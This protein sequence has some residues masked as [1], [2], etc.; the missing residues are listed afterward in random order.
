MRVDVDI[1]GTGS[2]GIGGS[3]VGWAPPGSVPFVPPFANLTVTN[4]K[5]TETKTVALFGHTHS[6]N[7]LTELGAIA[8]HLVPVHDVESELP[9]WNLGSS[10]GFWHWL[11]VSA[12]KFRSVST[13]QAGSDLE[14]LSGKLHTDKDFYSDGC[15]SAGGIGT[16]PS[17]SGTSV[18]WETVV[19]GSYGTLT[20]D[21]SADT[22]VNLSIYGHNHDDLY[23]RTENT[24]NKQQVLDLI[25][26]ITGFEYVIVQTLPEP[27]G[28][29]T[30]YKI[31]LVPATNPATGNVYNEF[32]TIRTGESPYTY[33]WE[34]IGSTA[35]DLNGFVTIATA[36]TITGQKTFSSDILP[37]SISQNLGDTTHGWGGVYLK[38][39]G[40]IN[41]GTTEVA[42]FQT[43]LIQARSLLPYTAGGYYLG[44][45]DKPW[46]SLSLYRYIY[47]VRNNNGT[48]ESATLIGQ[49]GSQVYIG[50]YDLTTWGLPT[51]IYSGGDINIYAKASGASSPT[52]IM[53][54]AADK[55]TSR[56]NFVPS[57]RDNYDLGE[58]SSCW[59]NLFASRWYLAGSSGPYIDYQTYNGG[60]YIVNH[61][62]F[63]STGAVT[64]GA[65][66]ADSS[67][68][69]V[70]NNIIPTSS[71]LAI[72]SENGNKFQ[73]IYATNIG[74]STAKVANVHAVSANITSA[75]IITLTVAGTAS[76]KDSLRIDSLYQYL[77]YSSQEITDS[78]VTDILDDS[79][80]IDNLLSGVYK[81]INCVNGTVEMKMSVAE[82]SVSSS[83]TVI[84]FGRHRRLRKY[85]GTWT[86]YNYWD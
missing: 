15:I 57:Y 62:N 64:A 73:Y 36:Q 71:T 37:S 49:N 20:V 48:Y 3:R 35:I 43:S 23:Y 8:N 39:N 60:N 18:E 38:S 50:S 77:N 51:G 53:Q 30:M 56:V 28:E 66:G 1:K 74:S 42:K 55:I 31:Y 83:E 26:G 2:G 76:L 79:E 40:T 84:Y 82:I 32:I 45:T 59:R 86:Y 54:M 29:R 13:H 85:S 63:I 11:F 58:S 16:T 65:L 47:L 67:N 10:T 41:V 34:Q 21:D 9:V 5:K 78:D 7:S 70:S 24:F 33:S 12:I 52:H 46:L 17:P 81:A 6:I 22:P 69:E 75:N 14:V 44:T 61:G 68:G 80:I 72:G 25:A 4:N 27:P 19:A